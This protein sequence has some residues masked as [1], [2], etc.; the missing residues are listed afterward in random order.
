MALTYDKTSTYAQW[1]SL[2]EMVLAALTGQQSQ[3]VNDT[4][5]EQLSAALSDYYIREVSLV[6]LE[7]RDALYSYLLID[8]KISAQV[9]TTRLAEAIASLQFYTHRVLTSQEGGADTAALTRQ[10]FTDWD[11]YNARYTTWAAVSKL[12]YYPENYVD[13]TMRFGQTG[14]MDRL[15]QTMSQSTLNSDVVESGVFNYLTAFEEIAN[16]DVVSGYH[17]NVDINQGKSYF[18]STSQ[19]EPK[20]FYW[21]SVDHSKSI[22]GCFAANAWSEWTAV[23]CA[24]S[25]WD[26]IIRPV[27]L[28]S[29]L[30]ICWIERSE[31]MSNDGI[32]MSF[33]Y[34]LKLSRMNYD[35]GWS[36]PFTYDVTVMISAISEKLNEL[37]M[38]CSEYQGESS[39]IIYFYKKE[40]H[41][42][43]AGPANTKGLYIYS[44]MTRH[45]INMQ[46]PNESHHFDQIKSKTYFTLDTLDEKKLNNIY[47]EYIQIDYKVISEEANSDYDF[48]GMLSDIT[49]KNT[50]SSEVL[51]RLNPIQQISYANKFS[52]TQREQ[53]IINYYYEKYQ[54]MELFSYINNGNPGAF[55]ATVVNDIVT[56]YFWLDVSNGYSIGS[57]YV[58]RADLTNSITIT[59]D[60]IYQDG[61]IYFIK[62]DIPQDKLLVS[63]LD[64]IKSIQVHIFQSI[65]SFN[66]HLDE[67]KHTHSIAPF[68]SSDITFKTSTMDYP[69]YSTNASNNCEVIP[70]F[71][72]DVPMR[73]L[74]S[75]IN[76][77]LTKDFQ[78]KETVI[79][80]CILSAVSATG[81]SATTTIDIILNRIPVN[82]KDYISLH[83]A[84]NNARYMQQSVYRT[85]L[86]TLFATQLI[87]KA[88]AG[89]DAILS[90]DTQLL[91][92]PKLG[93][94]TYVT[95]KLDVYDSVIHGMSREFT[96][97][98]VDVYANG[99]R[100]PLSSGFL[101][102]TENTIV[103]FFVPTNDN[104]NT[105]YIQAHYQK[106]DTNKIRLKHDKPSDPNS[107]KVDTS[108]NQGTFSGL[109]SIYGLVKS[110]EAMDFNGANALYFW[111]LFYYTPMMVYQRLLQESQYEQAT[112]W[113]K[114]IWNP[115]GYVVHGEMQSYYWNCRPLEEDTSWNSTPLDSVDPDAIS[116]N[117][118][119][120]YKVATFMS[121]LDLLIGRGDAAYRQ[122]CR[123][124]LNEAKMWY[125]QALN[126]LGEEAYVPLNGKWEDPSLDL[127][128]S[129]TILYDDPKVMLT[130]HGIEQLGSLKTSAQTVL[131]MPEVNEKLQDYWKILSQRLYNLRHNLSIDGQPLSPLLYDTPISPKTLQST[132]ITASQEGTEL[133][134]VIMPVQRFSFIQENA[135]SLVSQLIQF[136]STL[137][138]LIERQD[139]E[140]LT[141]LLQTQ[142]RELSVTS[143]AMQDKVIAEIDTDEKGLQSN[144]EGIQNRYISYTTLYNENINTG[145][146]QAMDLYLSSSV[147]AMSGNAF[148]VT[149]AAMNLVPNIYGLAVGG[150]V[151]GSLFNAMAV[152]TD[153]ASAATRISG[154]RISSN[155]S[156]RR[157]RQDWAIQRRNTENELNQIDAQLASLSIRREA[158]VLQK[159]YLERQQ[160]QTQVQLE[161]LQ[162]KFS[163]KALYNWLRGCL[164]SIYYQFYDLTVSRCLMSQQ[165]FRWEMNQPEASFIK[166]GGWNSTYA[167]LM[168]GENLMLNLTQMDDAYLKQDERPMEV[169]R[170]VSLAQRYAALPNNNH[171]VLAE[172]IVILIDSEKGQIGTNENGLKLEAGTL[173]SSVELSGLDII[174]DYPDDL[175]AER[176]I[177]QISVTLP[178]QMED[179]QDVQAVLSYGGSVVMPRGCSVL[180]ISH[181]INDNGQFQLNF[182]DINL[183]PFE[184]IPINDKGTLTLS[185]PN[186]T[187]KQKTLLRG[188]KDI[189]LH[190]RYT[191]RH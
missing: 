25:P 41:Y 124:T 182:N 78:G 42:T 111:E 126:L 152:G 174:K 1:S 129:I 48:I 166:P 5:S 120:H 33:T 27:Q 93:E 35:G 11:K 130:D 136:G 65:G 156:Y 31:K 108:Y 91:P 143:I 134:A 26:M 98:Y 62:A 163:S 114:Y 176:R 92:E 49:C 80:P 18:V 29:R 115:A 2:S 137:L 53:A 109:T 57:I 101:S 40:A 142:A 12:V 178:M 88:S 46:I 179:Y 38:F 90:M 107:W 32:T 150:S 94:G 28:N 177:K 51:L 191:I 185:F 187:S 121:M 95:L 188:L 56:L 105:V 55:I 34:A 64:L 165:A 112:S 23:T 162:R 173:I 145:E 21:R 70:S 189:I 132:A 72:Y 97:N 104:Q 171:F 103:S 158:A 19:T 140:A 4:L 82:V 45:D 119:M 190:I 73:Y 153:I 59:P 122:L 81:I 79:L 186:A 6:I 180:A 83:H 184:G 135:R 128:A 74:F 116:Q 54:G 118:P 66:C 43:N 102:D 151:Y 61:N 133:P 131:F 85:R 127:A 44:D 160:V 167:G 87:S 125:M 117:D 13:P 36:S 110:S 15:L 50:S 172:S 113:L 181:G 183:L 16:L 63:Q 7:N 14:M 157:R 139:S 20:K 58:K 24:I 30:F 148:R 123:D 76:F 8:N 9:K 175:G 161:Y 144:R 168:A 22:Q 71:T 89:L 106:G 75:G 164:S 84:P 69:G 170:T 60:S 17:N 154:D 100:F 68:S 159:S 147:I 169:L 39:L 141:E 47:S 37:S 146:Q 96:I 138:N 149:A 77:D 86:N 3:V 10:F 52:L 99:D 67:I 155:E